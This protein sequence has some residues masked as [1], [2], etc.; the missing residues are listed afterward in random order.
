M[1]TAAADFRR[2][3]KSQNKVS[4]GYGR[5][6]HFLLF[7]A[8][9]ETLPATSLR[10]RNKLAESQQYFPR[11]LHPPR[12]AFESQVVTSAFD[13]QQLC[14]TRNHLQRLLELGD[15]AERISCALDETG[16]RG[17]SREMLGALL[18]GLARRVQGIA[19][20]E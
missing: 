11:Q 8:P 1:V 6:A 15:C 19:E 4:R 16:G 2:H 13:H 20:Q 18:L 12:F 14:F 10:W 17:Q 5:L 7:L 3:N 9:A